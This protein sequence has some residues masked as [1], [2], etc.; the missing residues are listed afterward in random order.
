MMPSITPVAI[1]GRNSGKNG[2]LAS[3]FKMPLLTRIKLSTGS[4]GASNSN[5]AVPPTMKVCTP[6]SFGS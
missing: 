6:G 3:A 2:N 4:N 5:C 1:K